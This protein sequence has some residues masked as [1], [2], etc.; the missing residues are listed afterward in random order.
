MRQEPD[1]ETVVMSDHGFARSTARSLNTFLISRGL[2][3]KAYALGLNGLYCWIEKRRRR[4]GASCWITR[5]RQ[6]T[7]MIESVTQTNHRRRTEAS[8]RT[9]LSVYSA[10]YEHPGKPR[11][12][13]RPRGLVVDNDDAWM[14]IIASIRRKSPQCCLQRGRFARKRPG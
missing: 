6:R 3:A 9:S 10:G 11:W 7:H 4:Y 5:P 13:K 1:A 8:R 14:P 12:G 2:Q